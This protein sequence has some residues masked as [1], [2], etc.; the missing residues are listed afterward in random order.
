MHLF[1]VPKFAS[2]LKIHCKQK[3]KRSLRPRLENLW[4]SEEFKRVGSSLAEIGL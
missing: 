1:F 2:D 4:R 3:D